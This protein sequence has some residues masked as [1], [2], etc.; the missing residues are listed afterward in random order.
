M[1]SERKDAVLEIGMEEI[2][3]RFMRQA[4]EDARARAV[5]LLAAAR[6]DADKVLALGSPRRI[7]VY[8]EG[9]A[10]SQPDLMRELRGPAAAAAYG[11]DGLPTK[12][13]VGFARSAGVSV[14]SL[15]R[16]AT[17]GGEYMFAHAVEPGRS[18]EA[19]LTEIFPQIISA[20]SFPKLMRWGSHD[21]RY[22]RPIRWILALHGGDIANFQWHDIR[23][24]RTTMGHRTLAPG[25]CEIRSASEYCD[26]LREIG[27]MLDPEARTDSIREQ[28]NVLA[29]AHGGKAIIDPELL[30]EVTFLVEWPTA[31]VG[32]FSREYL[33]L[34]EACV[35]T[36]MKDHQRYFPVRDGN[37]VL[38][39]LFIAIRNGG[40]YCLDTVRAGNEK[41][42]AAR[43][44][45]AKFFYDED[46]RTPLQDRIE[47]LRELAFQ[48]KLGT[49][50]EKAE[51]DRELVTVLL[52]GDAA[53]A[54]AQRAAEL[55]K[56]DLVT[57]VVR[58]FT[59][60]QGVMG[61]E[62]GIRQGEAP[63]V[64]Q[65]V[66]EHYLPRFAGDAL[67]AT[68][69]GAA[70][71]VA[72]KIDTI[73]GYFGLGLIPTGSADPYALR[74]QAAGLVA[75]HSQWRFDLGLDALAE[76]AAE[77]YDT[78]GTLG[79]T[80]EKTV[81]DVMEFLRARV[82]AALE[83]AGIRYDIADAALASGV[84]R[85]GSVFERAR[86]LSAVADEAWFLALATAACRVRNIAGNTESACF[87]TERFE[88]AAESA[89]YDAMRQLEA[90]IRPIVGGGGTSHGAFV[91]SAAY[92]SSLERMSRVTQA[93][94]DYFQAV[95]VM[96]P[97]PQ[98]REN[99]LTMLR[100]VQSILFSVG[101]FSRVVFSAKES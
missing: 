29:L 38:L 37:G 84:A 96:A 33:D 79:E 82:K 95:M 6:L 16:R 80:R 24:G 98:V 91:D 19:V 52:S 8:L 63:D 55:A 3:A 22:V 66:F 51:R 85:P 40:D 81:A 92:Q 36:P 14:G 7:A 42:L 99:R 50:Y 76:K 100:W 61:R 59:E 86:A 39:P 17:A 12:A 69:A 48:E 25:L 71:S 93:V 1:V 26:R 20:L 68:R 83:E 18:A 78:A 60:L 58:E 57:S 46:M 65:A 27:V 88:D 31:F 67:P 77:L 34:P 87:T 49:M 74:R 2:P 32:A 64:A 72:D 47:A 23:S 9:V 43:L 15:E 11:P 54:A 62:Y 13:A 35:I 21:Y 10:P 41:V 28:A 45:D 70:L 53:L 75:V 94:N 4:I 56:A 5:E 30:E 44:A 73:V 89:L 101:D 97:D 90:D